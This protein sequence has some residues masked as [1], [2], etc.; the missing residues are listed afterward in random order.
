MIK[1]MKKVISLYICLIVL[2]FL[3]ISTS[4]ASNEFLTGMLERQRE[5]RDAKR[6]RKYKYRYNRH[7]RKYIIRPRH[8]DLDPHDG[9]FDPGTWSNPYI[10]EDNYGH[11]VGTIRPRYYDLDPHDGF[12]DPGTWSNPYEIEFEDN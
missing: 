7:R 9:F 11:K 4:F 1:L 2:I 12:F 5:L 6:S 10:V 3:P 8:Y